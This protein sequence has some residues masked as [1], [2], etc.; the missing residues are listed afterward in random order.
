LSLFIL[1]KSTLRVQYG[2]DPFDVLI[3]AENP[4]ALSNFQIVGVIRSI[5]F[6]VQVPKLGLQREL[7]SAFARPEFKFYKYS[8]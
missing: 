1:Q 5:V 3:P 7:I 4:I 8:G 2:Q 6:R